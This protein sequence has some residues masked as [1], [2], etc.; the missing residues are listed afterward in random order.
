MKSISNLFLLGFALIIFSSCQHNRLKTDEKK[1]AREIKNQENE[2]KRETDRIALEAQESDTL[3]NLPA[4]FRF[5]EDRSVD[6]AHPPVV[7]DF[8]KEIPVKDVK[9]S[10]IASAVKYIALSV[11]GDSIYFLWGASLNFTSNNIIINNNLGI[12]SFDR[13]G[14]FIATIAKNYLGVPLNI[15]PEKPFS[16]FFPKETFRGVWHNHVR[17]AGNMILY[18]YTDYPEGRVNLLKFSLSS[19]SPNILVPQDSET[20]SPSTYARGEV[21]A[22]GKEAIRSGTP[23][24]S[25]IGIFPIAENCYAGMPG[26]VEA[27]DGKNPLIVLFNIN[28]DTLCTFTQF[29][30]LESPI[31]NS[32]IRTYSTPRWQTGKLTSIKFAFNDTVFR[33]IPPNRL[34]PA[35]VFKLGDSKVTADEW[36]H[37]NTKLDRKILISSILENQQFMF[38]E[39]R[40]YIAGNDKPVYEKAL[41]DKSRNELIRLES[42]DEANNKI[43]NYWINSFENDLDGGPDFWPDYTTPEGNLAKLLRTKDLKE[44]IQNPDYKL[45]TDSKKEAFKAYVQSMK[46]GGRDI[47]IMI[48]E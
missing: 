10:S 43:F 2:N 7:I 3:A 18:K 14:R 33:I 39:Y 45:C 30:N 44:Y 5:K 35:Y 34:L 8:S 21:I 20:G 37:V 29:E 46:G 26:L 27:F 19:N 38:I 1:L 31:T 15:D 42:N 11:P 22:T 25:S 13:E 9:L 47:V 23:G 32:V 17:T 4:G 41:F 24:L 6:P 40:H 36:L 48:V 12:Q 28:G 16:G